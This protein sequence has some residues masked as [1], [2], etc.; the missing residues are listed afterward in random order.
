MN[1]AAPGVR[2]TDVPA[3]PFQPR[4]SVSQARRTSGSTSSGER[5][6][7]SWKRTS[8]RS[9]NLRKEA[10]MRRRC[11]RERRPKAAGQS[12][13]I[14]RRPTCQRVRRSHGMSAAVSARTK[15]R[16]DARAGMAA[17]R[18]TSGHGNR[19]APAE[20]A[21]PTRRIVGRR[22]IPKQRRAGGPGV[23]RQHAGAKHPGHA[24][25]DQRQGGQPAAFVGHDQCL[26]TGGGGKVRQPIGDRLGPGQRRRAVAPLPEIVPCRRGGPKLGDR[27]ELLDAWHL[28]SVDPCQ[29][30]WQVNES[31]ERRRHTEKHTL[32][33]CRLVRPVNESCERRP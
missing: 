24:A 33:P 17:S 26:E 3:A 2:S 12:C 27:V 8:P 20:T 31:C 4:S 13:P 22:G 30:A 10:E 9:A 1:S 11:L 14:A 6:A 21:S 15:A 19:A 32:D 28:A 29:L 7:C 16:H 23:A 5:C 25:L 18:N